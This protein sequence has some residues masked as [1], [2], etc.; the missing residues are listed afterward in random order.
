MRKAARARR[1]YGAY[2]ETGKTAAGRTALAAARFAA[3]F[4][5]AAAVLTGCGGSGDADISAYGDA[6]IEI[7]GLTDT[8]FV[9][10]PNELMAL[11]CVSRSATGETAKAGTVKATGPLLD[12][13]LEKYNKKASDF[14]RIRFIASDAYRVVLRDEYLTDYEVVLSVASGGDP[15]PVSERPLRILIP[16]AESSMWEYACVRIEFVE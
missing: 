4:I 6:P 9:I 14:N 1:A 2:E 7:E 13:F 5:L 16:D 3:L 11:P 12:T 8:A 10:T 15:L